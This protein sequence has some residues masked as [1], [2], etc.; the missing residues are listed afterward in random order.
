MG[1]GIIRR[2]STGKLQTSLWSK[3]FKRTLFDGFL[4]PIGK[5][6]EEPYFYFEKYHK[7]AKIGFIDTQ[8]YYYRTTPNSIMRGLSNRHIKD[9]IFLQRYILKQIE[10]HNDLRT[11]ISN[12]VILSMINLWQRCVYGNAPLSDLYLISDF[13]TE[14][15]SNFGISNTLSKKNRLILR[16]SH[17]R[18]F[19]YI[20]RLYN[21]LK[22]IK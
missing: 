10:K 12:K 3:I 1:G 21:T 14:T 20:L 17:N 22:L 13:L 15:K 11:E 4:F 8:L 18:I 5:I 7:V 2:F 6:Y 16:Q 9:N 19:I